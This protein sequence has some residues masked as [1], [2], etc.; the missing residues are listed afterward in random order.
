M[1]ECEQYKGTRQRYEQRTLRWGRGSLL[2]S[3]TSWRGRS[4]ACTE[5]RSVSLGSRGHCLGDLPDRL[6]QAPQLSLEAPMA[7][8][9]GL[10]V[11]TQAAWFLLSPE[12]LSGGAGPWETTRCLTHFLRR[13]CDECRE[14]EKQNR[15]TLVC[16][17]RESFS[18]TVTSPEHPAGGDVRWTSVVQE[19]GR[20]GVGG[21]WARGMES[22]QGAA[23][24]TASCG[25]GSIPSNPCPFRNLGHGTPRK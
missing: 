7:T 1:E 24:G 2:R 16:A 12:R 6:R 4:G 23:V 3:Y 13:P 21:G 10:L 9:F 20:W 22:R 18:E 8:H 5:R 11:F 25:L 17:A 15:A 19:D 14:P